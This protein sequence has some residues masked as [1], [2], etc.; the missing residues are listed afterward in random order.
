[1]PCLQTKLFCLRASLVLN[2]INKQSA[3]RSSSSRLHNRNINL[4]QI[5]PALWEINL[6]KLGYQPSRIELSIDGF[7]CLSLVLLERGESNC[8]LCRNSEYANCSVGG[9]SD[10]CAIEI[11]GLDSVRDERWGTGED[12]SSDG[13]GGCLEA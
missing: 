13:V 3:Q 4:S 10:E 2:I 9:T 8:A 1:M 7:K 12:G 6:G 11:E 5:C